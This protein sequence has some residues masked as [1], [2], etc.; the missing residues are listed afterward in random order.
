MYGSEMHASGNASHCRLLNEDCCLA[1]LSCLFHRWS[2]EATPLLK[3]RQRHHANILLPNFLVPLTV[4][5]VNTAWKKPALSHS[6]FEREKKADE[7]TTSRPP[8]SPNSQTDKV[9]M[10]SSTGHI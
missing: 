9:T 4:M 1:G 2:A 8:R 6:D 7:A 3:P 10:Q 5:H